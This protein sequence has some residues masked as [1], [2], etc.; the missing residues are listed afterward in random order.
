[1]SEHI[2]FVTAVNDRQVYES[3]FAASLCFQGDHGHEIIVQEGFRSAA[4]AYNDAID[5]SENDLIV[6]AHQDV[7]FPQGW[8]EDLH[9]ALTSLRQ[10]DPNWGVLG[11]YGVIPSERPGRGFVYSPYDGFLGSPHG[12]PAA[13]QTLDEIV[14]ILRRSKGLRFTDDLPHFHFYGTD[15]CMSAAKRGMKSYAVAA[16]CIHN[17]N[18]NFVLPKEFY[19][20][21]AFAKRTWKE[22]LPIRTTCIRITRFDGEMYKRRLKDIYQRRIKRRGEG[23]PRVSDGRSL[24][25]EIESILRSSEGHTI[26]CL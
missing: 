11:C 5:R 12:L 3:N 4:S 16:L 19:E 21:Y 23:L 10:K 22:F 8:I 7:L 9:T 2:T 6:F 14:L 25:R 24:Y 18:Q 17:S 26:P 20:S 1:M 15:I 13:V